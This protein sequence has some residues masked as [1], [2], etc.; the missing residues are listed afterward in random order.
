MNLSSLPPMRVPTLT[1]VVE[2]SPLKLAGPEVAEVP[3]NAHLPVLSEAVLL[4]DWPRVEAGSAGAEEAPDAE[5]AL[6]PEAEAEAESPP[7]PIDEAEL[8]QRIVGDIQRQVDQMLEHRVQAALT[9]MLEEWTR[10]LAQQARNE[11]ALTLRDVVA[12]AVALE[13]ARHRSSSD[14]IE[15]A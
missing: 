12:E 2:W 6:A 7:M 4:Q 15:P 13:L 14:R 3:D 10:T 11:L 1:E 8:T 9:P 5:V